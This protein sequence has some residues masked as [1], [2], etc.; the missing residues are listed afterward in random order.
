M[1]QRTYQRYDLSAPVRFDW[2]VSDITHGQGTGI[3]RDLSARGLFVLTADNLPPIGATVRFELDLDTSRLDSPVTVRAK[4]Q[5][6]RIEV[7]DSVGR[8]GG[9]AISTRRMRLTPFTLG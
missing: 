2:E 6:N 9:F 5:V 4:G 3:T 7:T 8:L 1:E